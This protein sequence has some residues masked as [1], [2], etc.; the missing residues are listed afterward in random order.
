VVEKRLP[1][2]IELDLARCSSRR[3]SLLGCRGAASFEPSVHAHPHSSSLSHRQR[4]P[5]G[6]TPGVD[7]H[8][9]P[10]GVLVPCVRRSVADAHSPEPLTSLL[11]SVLRPP[12]T[13]RQSLARHPHVSSNKAPPVSAQH[14]N[15]LRISFPTLPVTLRD[16]HAASGPVPNPTDSPL[17]SRPQRG[18]IDTNKRATRAGLQQRIVTKAPSLFLLSSF[19]PSSTPPCSFRDLLPVFVL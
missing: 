5:L 3:L 13:P 18:F 12:Q 2:A 1:R 10:E 11:F 17:L 4:H 19:R 15:P 9:V 16:G 14:W 6:R 8:E 7:L